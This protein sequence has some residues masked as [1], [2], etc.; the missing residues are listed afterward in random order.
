MIVAPFAG[1][2][3]DRT[4]SRPLMAAGLALPVGAAFLAV[5]ALLALLVPALASGL[6]QWSWL[7][8]PCGGDARS[9]SSVTAR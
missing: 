4:G 7:G 8:V 9:P 3:S 6:G 2:L 5:G 1:V